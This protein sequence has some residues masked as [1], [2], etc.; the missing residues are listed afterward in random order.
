M[1]AQA[2]AAERALQRATAPEKVI[3]I[4]AKLDGI[5]T[6]MHRA[7]LFD[8]EAFGRS[9]A[10]SCVGARKGGKESSIHIWADERDARASRDIEC[11]SAMYAE[12]LVDVPES[13][14]RG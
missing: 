12:G 9:S 14:W 7:N 11:A 6:W 13:T 1:L 5:E 4:E 8:T 10:G 3:K 2:R